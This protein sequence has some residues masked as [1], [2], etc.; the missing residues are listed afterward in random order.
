MSGEM[1]LR[2]L[3]RSPTPQPPAGV[4][5][6]SRWIDRTRARADRIRR[7]V[8]GVVPSS[9]GGSVPQDLLVAGFATRR[10]PPQ[11]RRTDAERVRSRTTPV[12][13]CVT[14]A[15][16]AATYTSRSQKTAERAE[17]DAAS[18]VPGCSPVVVPG[19][20]RRDPEAKD[21]GQ[22]NARRETGPERFG[23]RQTNQTSTETA[24]RVPGRHWS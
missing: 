3:E 11:V 16:A 24:T 20:C 8:A 5:E 7:R 14:Q 6:A 10:P 22:A 21:D 9:A 17:L 13:R 23:K 18:F 1:A 2:V 4:R 12:T 15:G 19:W